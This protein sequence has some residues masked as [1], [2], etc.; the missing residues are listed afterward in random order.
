[1]ERCDDAHCAAPSPHFRMLGLQL[2]D[3]LAAGAMVW[4]RTS[5][6]HLNVE[7]VQADTIMSGIVQAS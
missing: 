7:D 2:R 4:G 5:Q 1:V 3:S 6:I